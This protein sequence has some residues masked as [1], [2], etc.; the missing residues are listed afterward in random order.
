MQLRI[1]GSSPAWPNPGSACSGHLVEG[2]LLLDCGPG[3]L[4]KLRER[5]DWPSVEAIAITHLHLDH[6]GDLVPWVWGT[7]FGPGADRQ[8][9]ELW[10]PPDARSVLRPLLARL[11]GE[12]ILERAF[13][14]SEYAVDEPFEAA[15][16]RLTA[17]RVLHY[18]VA[19]HGF[20]VE[21]ERT[22]AYSGDSGPCDSLVE[23]AADADLLLC[24]ATLGEDD[25]EPTPRGH[26]SATEALAVQRES[27]AQRLLLTH[28]PLERPL[29][30][31]LELAHDGL[32]VEV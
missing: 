29:P 12:T 23:L 9:T 15:G 20:R 6:W 3:V 4:A 25:T 28:R 22:L 31:G 14:V 11:G 24:E 30:D 21:G 8:R 5:E 16:L 1:V 19:A 17:H 32:V 13:A 27:G 10:L 7:L 26:L 2:R 18:D